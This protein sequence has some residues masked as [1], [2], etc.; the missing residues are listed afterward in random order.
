MEP[1]AFRSILRQRTA[2]GSQQECEE[3]SNARCQHLFATKLR[4]NN[5]ATC[6]SAADTRR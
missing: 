2:Q 3:G 6:A 4:S 5:I 1:H